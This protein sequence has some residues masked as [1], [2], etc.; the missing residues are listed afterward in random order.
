MSGSVWGVSVVLFQHSIENQF[1]IYTVVVGLAG[2]AIVTLGAV[3]QVYVA[4]IFPM[5]SIS[6][7]YALFQD[8][9]VY[10][11]TAVFIAGLSVFLYMSAKNY[12]NN[13]VESIKDKEALL[14]TQNEIV[15]RLSKAGKY[16]DNE[17][18]MHI[19]RMS[20][21]YGLLAKK[22]GFMREHWSI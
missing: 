7:L 6:A 11:S 13:F 2:A 17:T 22:Y 1:F 18:G 4:F 5:L 3:F 19:V 12:Y 16:R 21:V 20:H 14:S 8:G 15:R 9:D 10:K